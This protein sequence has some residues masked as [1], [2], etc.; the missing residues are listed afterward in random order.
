MH[1]RACALTWTW[2]RSFLQA[3][4]YH[5]ERIVTSVLEVLFP[6]T[7]HWCEFQKKYVAFYCCVYS[8]CSVT[9]YLESNKD[10][11]ISKNLVINGS[12]MIIQILDPWP[13]FYFHAGICMS[14]LHCFPWTD[15]KIVSQFYCRTFIFITEYNLQI[16]NLK[17]WRAVLSTL[18]YSTTPI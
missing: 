18:L 17:I 12:C 16:K 8:N 7:S 1:I 6:L 14:L 15:Q 4:I 5:N 2:R 10:V 9:P 13:G 3:S 11:R